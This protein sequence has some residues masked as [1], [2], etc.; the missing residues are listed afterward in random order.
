MTIN[1]MKAALA[2]ALFGAMALSGC[3]TPPGTNASTGLYD[4]S[5]DNTESVPYDTWFKD[6][7]Q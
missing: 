7:P 5:S 6:R 4:P 2:A 3:A 1:G